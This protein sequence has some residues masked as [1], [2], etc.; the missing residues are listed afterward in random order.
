MEDNMNTAISSGSL[1]RQKILRP[2]LIGGF[3]AGFLD[4]ITAFI[5]YGWGVP[6]AIASGLLGA[7]A[8]HGGVATW[9]L[10]VFLQ[11]FIAYSAA[12]VYCV[13][14]LKL[15]FL[16]DHF[17]VCGL[18]YGIAVYLVMNLIVLPLSAVP[19]KI[20]PFPVAGLIQGLLVHMFIIGLPISFSLRKFS[21]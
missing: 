9:I 19:F 12:V 16:K 2:I 21:K 5:T 17:F 11:F 7:Q 20:G 3:V 15:K 4:L 6:R 13:A 14:S 18:F 8:L 1:Q 10:G